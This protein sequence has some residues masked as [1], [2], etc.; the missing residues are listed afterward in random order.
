[1]KIINTIILLNSL[2]KGYYVIKD[3]KK[4]LLD[5]N[6]YLCQ[7][8]MSED[9]LTKVKKETLLKVNLGIGL[10]EFIDWTDTF[11]QDEI[12]INSANNVLNDVKR[13]IK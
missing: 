11:T 4:Y 10:K 12:F 1:M 7:V 2:L 5:S 8:T 6:Y 9:T 13:G 3:N